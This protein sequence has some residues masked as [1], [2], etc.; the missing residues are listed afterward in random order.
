MTTQSR[1]HKSIK[2]SLVALAYYAVGLVLSFFSRKIFL[3]YLGTEVLGL[4]TTAQNLLQFLNLAELG[5]GSAVGFSLYKPLRE[6]D[7]VTVNEIVSLQGIVYK[8]IGV[9]I[10]IG[11]MILMAFFPLIFKKMEL[12]LWYAFASFGVL[13][14]SSLLGYF[15]NYKQVL[16]TSSQK[17]YKVQ[18]SYTSI[19]LIKIVFQMMAIYY[20]SNGYVWWLILEGLFA[21]VASITLHLTTIKEFP[22]LK[23]VKS[24]YKELRSKYGYL[25]T[26]IKQ[27]FFHKIAGFA[28][29]QSSPLII[30]AL[31]DLTIVAIYG[32]YILIIAGIQKIVFAMFNGMDAGVGN[33]VVEG[34][35][36]KIRN[37]FLELF[38]IRFVI[39]AVLSFGFYLMATPFTIIWVGSDYLLPQSTLLL[40][41]GSLFIMLE[42]FTVDTF[43]NAY[44]IYG[45]IWAPIVETVL[46]IGLSILFG[47]Y[48][49]LNGIIIGVIISQ[50]LII[51]IWKPIYLILK[52]MRNFGTLYTKNFIVHLFIGLFLALL[53]V[54][55]KN[56]IDV[57]FMTNPMA[58]IILEAFLTLFYAFLLI[59]GLYFLTSGM[60]DGIHRFRNIIS[61]LTNK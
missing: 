39:A 16:L 12:P 32:N 52:R 43:I 25:I 1:T 18:Y 49:G 34:N 45:D 41:S 36:E 38:S 17:N 35:N 30:Y 27:L 6:N 59:V 9:F 48:Y 23:E 61:K 24:S 28:L 46:N 53:I 21:M 5:I 14:F 4:N 40:L 11:S 7:Q 37:V 10:L 3:D 50:V 15:V 58:L 2:N 19:N 55:L 33:L 20:F 29:T 60:K 47:F 22:A 8:K 57:S 44:G 56:R 54:L 26:K 13:L 31:I 51:I 42:R